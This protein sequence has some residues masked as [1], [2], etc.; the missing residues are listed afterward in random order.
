MPMLEDGTL[1]RAEARTKV[2]A[3]VEKERIAGRRADDEAATV[4]TS[5]ESGAPSQ[6][7]AGTD[8]AHDVE[9]RRQMEIARKVMRD[10]RNV[11]R[12]LAK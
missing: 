11:L 1:S 12:A 9:F 5:H 3:M 4:P 7:D 2:G 10:H 8:A 6:K